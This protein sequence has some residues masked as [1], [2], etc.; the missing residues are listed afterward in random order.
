[1]DERPVPDPQTVADIVAWIRT[2][3]SKL[4]PTSPPAVML[5]LLAMSIEA[6]AP[7]KP[8]CDGTPAEHIRR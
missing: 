2:R 6:H 5:D 8:S 3:A 7:W 4:P 1:M